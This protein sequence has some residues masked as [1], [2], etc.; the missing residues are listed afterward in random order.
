L[1]FVLHGDVARFP[2]RAHANLWTVR[3]S[4][5]HS[6]S[7]WIGASDLVFAAANVPLSFF[8]EQAMDSSFV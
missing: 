8:V 7:D 2:D 3:L 4:R 6:I 1:L 5:V